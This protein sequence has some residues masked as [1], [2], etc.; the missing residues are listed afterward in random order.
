MNI[1]H[2]LPYSAKFP[3]QKHNGRYEWALRLARLQ[4]AAGHTV[5][6]YAAPDCHDDDLAIKWQTIPFDFGNKTLNNIALMKQAFDADEHQIYH[7]HFDH[8]HYFLADATT[9]PVIFTQH[10]F[11]N[12]AVAAAQRYNTKNQALAVPVTTF[13]ATENRRLGLVS[14]SKIYH[15]IDLELFSLAAQPVRDRLVFIGRIAPHKGVR[16]IVKLAHKAGQKLDIIGKINASD[17]PYW[18]S[19]SQLVDGH[20][21]RYLGALS[22]TEVALILAAAKAFIFISQSV[23]AFGQTIIESQACGTPV[24]TNNMGAASELVH[25][26][27]TGFITSSD[28]AFIS[29]INRLDTIDRQACRDFAEHFDVN[30]MA[31][32]YESL[33]VER[34]ALAN[35]VE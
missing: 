24:I 34:I 33:Y 21:I 15:G 30:R 9:K 32:Q 19:F 14:A 12:G 5:T 17:R 7:S 11:P 3:L 20:Q 10:W 18:D 27:V 13:M 8:L 35:I 28:E 16:E 6:I 25:D 22:Q 29:A 2:L 31:A 23:E 4:V 1:A 26:G